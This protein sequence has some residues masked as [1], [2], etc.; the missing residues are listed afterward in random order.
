[1]ATFTVTA[2]ISAGTR[3]S[4]W[5]KTHYVVHA[6]KSFEAFEKAVKAWSVRGFN[7]VRNT[8]V[9]PGPNKILD[10]DPTQHSVQCLHDCSFGLPDDANPTD[11]TVC[12]GCGTR[13]DRILP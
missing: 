12:H 10:L 11:M 5:T 9:A 8:H 1:M 4:G 2:E 6:E 7:D 13:K 3:Y